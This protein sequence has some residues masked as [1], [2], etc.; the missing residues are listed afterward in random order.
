MHEIAES[1]AALALD[2][3][4][5]KSHTESRSE[6]MKL[7]ERRVVENSDQ[8]RMPQA[9]LLGKRKRSQEAWRVSLKQTLEAEVFCETQAWMDAEETNDAAWSTKLFSA[10]SDFFSRYVYSF[11]SQSKYFL[12]I[13]GAVLCQNLQLSIG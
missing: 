9:S 10:L 2:T 3:L 8:E 13:S 12:D 7:L 11:P 5:K 1:G 6:I 4:S